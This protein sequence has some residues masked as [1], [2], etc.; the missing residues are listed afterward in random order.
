MLQEYPKS[1]SETGLPPDPDE[2]EILCTDFYG[3]SPK[4]VRRA[5]SRCVFFIDLN[6]DTSF[7]LRTNPGWDGP[8]APQTIVSFVDFLSRN[9]AACPQIIPM[10]GGGLSRQ[11]GH[12]CVSGE[13]LL[14]GEVCDRVD[15][16][17][18]V[19]AE[20][21]TLH[22]IAERFEP[23][24]CTKEPV[25]KFVEPALAYCEETELANDISEAVRAF[26]LQVRSRLKTSLKT[27]WVLCR[28]DVRSWNVIVDS[29]G[30]VRF[31]DFNA[32]RYAPALFDLVMPRTQWLMGT[33]NRD[34]LDDEMREFVDGYRSVRIFS[35][36]DEEALPLIWAAYYAQRLCFL[37]RKW[38]PEAHNRSVW[39]LDDRLRGLPVD[40][41]TMAECVL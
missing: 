36:S 24:G 26:V 20:L 6:D 40:A 4:Q 32:A 19:G 3:I 2:I 29:D 25:A 12:F 21:A 10:A 38:S 30:T 33:E 39:R 22:N 7:V 11:M 28:G 37:H 5:N 17:N 18:D 14:P 41:L 35:D 1:R 9:G 8:V 27:K 34:L 15:C 23:Y 13:T 16:L 31:T